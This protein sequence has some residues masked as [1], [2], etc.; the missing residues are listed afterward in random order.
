MKQSGY[1]KR[2]KKQRD[3]DSYVNYVVARQLMVDLL[4]I[5]LN[6]ALHLGAESQKLVWDTF[7][8]LHDEYCTIWHQDSKDLEYSKEVIDRELKEICGKY[9]IPWEERYRV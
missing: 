3:E 9:F 7:S 8:K 5:A 6:R 1:L 4:T 2:L